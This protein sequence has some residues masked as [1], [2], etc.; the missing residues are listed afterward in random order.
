MQNRMRG[1]QLNDFLVI[2]IKKNISI[3]IENKK[4]I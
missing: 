4:I 3:N 2:Y 1:D